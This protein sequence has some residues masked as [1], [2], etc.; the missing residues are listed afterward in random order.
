VL[1]PQPVHS[2]LQGSAR[3]DAAL[4]AADKARAARD[5]NVQAAYARLANRW[6]DWATDP[7]HQA[8][9]LLL[10]LPEPVTLILQP[11]GRLA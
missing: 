2:L 1:M 3:G 4:E 11:A 10:Y 5:P 6:T 8:D 9:A 7:H